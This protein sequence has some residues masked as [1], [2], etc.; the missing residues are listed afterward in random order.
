VTNHLIRI[1]FPLVVF[2][3][4]THQATSFSRVRRA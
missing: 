4:F 2:G 1:D 3:I